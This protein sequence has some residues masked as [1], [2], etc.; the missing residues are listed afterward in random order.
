MWSW[1]MVWN[2]LMESL[3]QNLDEMLVVLRYVPMLDSSHCS[4]VCFGGWLMGCPCCVNAAPE[5]DRES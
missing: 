5:R 2:Q 1:L 4:G 3:K